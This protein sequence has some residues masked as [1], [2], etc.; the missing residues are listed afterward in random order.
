MNDTLPATLT[1]ATWTC[2]ATAGATCA[3]SGSGSIN[4]T[5]NLAS[6]ATATYTLTATIAATATGSLTNTATITAPATVTDP[7]ATNN[8][9]TQRQWKNVLFM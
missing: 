9:A 3:A 6:G 8:T 7:T 4:D 1:G 5:I 2:V